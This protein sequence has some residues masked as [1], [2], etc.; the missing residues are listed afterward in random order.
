MNG[1]HSGCN[2]GKKLGQGRC[3]AD[4]NNS[5]EMVGHGGEVSGSS[6]PSGPVEFLTSNTVGFTFMYQN[7]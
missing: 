2:W 7:I 1:D 6:N 3:H 4:I 5:V